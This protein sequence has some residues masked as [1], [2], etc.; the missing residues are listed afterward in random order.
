MKEI[1]KTATFRQSSITF[2]G[3]VINGLLGFA[4]IGI[5]A[6]LLQPSQYGL[7]VLTTTIL[8]AISD[9]FDFGTRSGLVRY[10]SKYLKENKELAFKFLKFTLEFKLIVAAFVT[11]GGWF[12]APIISINFFGKPEL[13]LPLQIGFIGVISL[14]AFSFSIA[15]LQAFQR[16]WI[17]SG[18]Q[19]G[20]NLLRLLIIFSLYYVGN[21]SL[22]N[23]LITYVLIPFLGF[24]FSFLFIPRKFLFVKKESG[25]VSE[26]FNYSKWIGA[27]VVLAAISARLDVFIVG[28]L[29]STSELGIYGI[30]NQL[31]MI[32]PQIVV[33]ISTVIAPKMAQMGT[34]KELVEYYKKTQLMVLGLAGLGLLGIPISFFVIPLLW[35]AYIGAIPIFAILLIA[36]LIFLIS[37]PIH[38]VI[39]YYFGY[40]KLF[41]WLSL[42]HLLIVAI[43]G[44]VLTIKF[45]LM[46]AAAA[47]LIGMVFNFIIPLIWGLKK[48][49][50]K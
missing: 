49:Y 43:F 12:L 10:V 21:L 48:M 15:T 35:Q 5:T 33:A 39:I 7:F 29:L 3:T 28:K 22:E 26:L 34:K 1:L 42:G 2:L 6:Q 11:I 44:W 16:F 4:F 8:I 9:I 25:V 45:G 19:I 23:T 17:W 41:F 20:T 50:E 36:M 24:I 13:I 18:I 40:P 30:A 31:S 27:F 32:V 37:I 38:S 14:S 46:G 47:V